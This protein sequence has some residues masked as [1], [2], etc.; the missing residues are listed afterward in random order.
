VIGR[1]FA[2]RVPLERFVLADEF[3]PRRE[4]ADERDDSLRAN[5]IGGKPGGTRAVYL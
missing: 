5:R 2:R 1:P 4:V 3:L